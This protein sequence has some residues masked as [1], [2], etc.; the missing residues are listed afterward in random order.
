MVTRMAFA[1]AMLMVSSEGRS[2]RRKEN[3]WLT[4][5]IQ[6]VKCNEQMFLIE[7]TEPSSEGKDPYKGLSSSSLSLSLAR[8]SS[9]PTSPRIQ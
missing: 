2:S 5:P 6:S 3:K 4:S 7:I 1:V 9:S 8:A